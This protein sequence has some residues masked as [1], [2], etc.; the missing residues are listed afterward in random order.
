LALFVWD[1][2]VLTLY[3][4]RKQQPEREPFAVVKARKLTI[5]KSESNEIEGNLQ[6]F[7]ALMGNL[8]YISSKEGESDRYIAC[9]FDDR[10]NDFERAGRRLIGV[11]FP[12]GTR[13][14]VDE[15]EKR[16]YNANFKAEYGKLE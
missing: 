4:D 10:D 2:L 11:T 3:R 1:K 5:T 16:T 14:A 12:T 13:F 9:W 8:D 15:R 7:F 6:D